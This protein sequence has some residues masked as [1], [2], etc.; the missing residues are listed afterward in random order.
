VISVVFD[1][2]GEVTRLLA[3]A[4]ACIYA[5]RR[6]RLRISVKPIAFWSAME[7]KDLLHRSCW[8][9]CHRSFLPLGI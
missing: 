8:S 7:N 2:L 5:D 6:L 4:G 9:I 3:I 1:T